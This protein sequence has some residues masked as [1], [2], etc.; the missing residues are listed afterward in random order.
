MDYNFSDMV[1]EGLNRGLNFEEIAADFTKTLN[2]IQK[3]K[4]EAEGREDYIYSCTGRLVNWY[5]NNADES[6]SLAADMATLAAYDVHYYWSTDRLRKFNEDAKAQ[7]EAL[8]DLYEMEDKGDPYALDLRRMLDMANER[9]KKD[10]KCDCEC[11]EKK[12][13]EISDAEVLLRFL[14][15]L[16]L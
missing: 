11:K 1:N 6:L 5:D 4:E 8:V 13:K 12:E 7:L 9:E 15:D 16:G 3:K 2:E 10:E 14:K